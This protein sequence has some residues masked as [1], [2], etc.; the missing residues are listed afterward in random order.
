MKKAEM[1][2]QK[3]LKLFNV[4]NQKTTIKFI[5]AEELVSGIPMLTINNTN[6]MKSIRDKIKKEQDRY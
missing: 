6:S 3:E 2:A 4:L 1:I 5:K